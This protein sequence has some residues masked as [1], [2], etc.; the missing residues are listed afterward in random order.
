MITIKPYFLFLLSVII[1]I[2][3]CF[4]ANNDSTL[5]INVHDTYY[6]V[7]HTHVYGFLGIILFTVF[8]FYWS[9]DKAKVK[10]IA[11]LSNIHIYGTLISIIG[12]F[13]PYSLLFK[14]SNFPLYD[15]TQNVN[16]CLSISGLLFL[17]FQIL[18]II[19]I[20]VSITKKI[21]NPAT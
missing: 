4:F 6:V 11:F 19:N 7:A 5:D 2:G 17:L 9:L 20:F 13:F 18:F 3:L 16:L 10:L 1:F 15:D 21:C 12:M 8:T 14:P